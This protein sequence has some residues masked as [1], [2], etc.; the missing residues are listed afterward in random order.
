MQ[1]VELGRT[2]KHALEHHHVQGVGVANRF[3]VA[4]RPRPRR[5]EPRRGAGIAARKQRYLVTERDQ[6]VGEPVDDALRAAIELRRNGLGQR[7]D[8]GDVH[9]CELLCCPRR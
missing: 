7:S 2:P 1:E 9:A 8:L 4:Y 6:L 5:V 3:V